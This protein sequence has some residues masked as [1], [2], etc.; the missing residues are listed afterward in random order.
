[1]IIRYLNKARLQ[2]TISL[3]IAFSGVFVCNVL[4]YQVIT[5]IGFYSDQQSQSIGTSDDTYQ[6]H[7]CHHKFDPTGDS[8]KDHHD[9]QS[10]SDDECCEEQAN[11]LYE[12]LVNYVFPSFDVEKVPM[13]IIT[14]VFE[15]PLQI[16]T[17]LKGIKRHHLNCTLSPPSGAVLRILIQ[18]FLN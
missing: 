3:L 16:T 11:L 18:S 10:R 9:H 2:I 8:N 12:N 1:M 4:C 5:D 7:G 17:V 13:L 14:L 15:E 6:K